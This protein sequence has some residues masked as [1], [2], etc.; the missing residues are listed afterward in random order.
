MNRVLEN[1]ILKK[2]NYISFDVFDTLIERDV[3]D[4]KDIFSIIEKTTDETDFRNKRIKAEKIARSKSMS[5]E[6]KLNEIYHEYEENQI[7]RDELEKME[8]K[9]EAQHLHKKKGMTDFYQRCITEGKTVFLVSDMYLSG[10]TLHQLLDNCGI[11]GYRALYVSCDYQ[12]N[13]VTSQ[14]FK[15]LLKDERIDRDKL[16]HI[17]DSPKA[18]YIGA[19]KAGI[20][21]ILIPKSNMMLWIKNKLFSKKDE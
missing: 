2:Y 16:L 5:G 9:T 17:G 10:K 18:D 11:S 1:H 3:P 12:D 21:S 4:P 15:I 13:K 8:I 20:H 7:S 6:V 14:L 19:H